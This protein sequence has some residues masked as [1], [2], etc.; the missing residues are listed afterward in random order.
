MAT[1]RVTEAVCATTC[2]IG[3]GLVFEA[4]GGVIG[5]IIGSAVPVIGTVV[6]GAIGAFFG[7]ILGGIIGSIFGR[8]CGSLLGPQVA[9]ITTKFVRDDVPVKKVVKQ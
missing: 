2:T 7:S 1:Q 5:G 8:A 9:K 6:G 4:G 3:L